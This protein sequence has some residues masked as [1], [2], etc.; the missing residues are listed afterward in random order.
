MPDLKTH[1]EE[2]I[3]KLGN[4]YTAVHIWLDELYAPNTDHRQHRHNAKA[5]E[6]RFVGK[7]LAAAR[8]H[9]ISDMGAIPKDRDDYLN[10]ID[11]WF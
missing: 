9:I 5:I 4:P 11:W 3:D 2:C 8:L 1:C 10:G 6:E 7:E